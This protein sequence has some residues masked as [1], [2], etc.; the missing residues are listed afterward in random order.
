MRRPM[1]NYDRAA[2]VLPGEHSEPAQ[3]S[4]SQIRAVAEALVDAAEQARRAGDGEKAAG[5]LQSAACALETQSRW[6]SHERLEQSLQALAATLPNPGRGHGPDQQRGKVWLHVLN[7]ALPYG[8]HTAMAAR[9]IELCDDGSSHNAVILSQT[10]PAPE[11]LTRAVA[12]K[13]GR[14]TVLD[15]AAPLLERAAQLREIAHASASRVVLHVDTYDAISA[16]AF[17]IDGGPPV[18]T[19]NHAAHLFWAGGSVADLVV[20]CRGSL[21]EERWTR[22]HR[23]LSRCAT[24]P[25]PLFAPAAPPIGGARSASRAEARRKL[26]LP[27]AACVILTVGD[28]YKYSPAMGLDFTKVC[29]ALLSRSR[30]LVVVAVGVT[31]DERWKRVS[32]A[33]GG[34]LKAVGKQRNVDEFRAAADLYIEGFPFG[35]TTALLEAG[36]AGMPVVLAPADCSPPF[37][38]DGVAID[39]TLQRPSDIQEY[40]SH[41]ERLV[42]D[43][44]ARDA[45]AESFH[46]AVIQHH[47]GA[48]WMAYLKAAED[49]LP[50]D[51]SIQKVVRTLETRLQDYRYWDCFSRESGSP[52]ERWLDSYIL[53]MFQAGARPRLDRIIRQACR[54][55]MLDRR[56]RT[57]PMPALA[58][59][60]NLVLPCLPGPLAAKTFRSLYDLCRPGSRAMGALQHVVPAQLW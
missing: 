32:E 55:H 54:R 13:G 47:T 48:G 59:V 28:T 24:V 56:G 41:I 53:R 38:S 44:A 46:R 2:P 51:H 9:W 26:G 27:E 29:E 21:L 33:F 6:L 16:I 17:G 40:Q 60:C 14:I 3:R 45:A 57:M 25:I 22:Y 50:K 49:E 18:L 4:T 12:A 37:G 20:N 39:G 36:L 58:L 19:V 15:P 5:L 7:R 10:V 11:A 30:E 23:G 42:F 31:G 35:S 52:P 1:S 34:R 43:P 8:G